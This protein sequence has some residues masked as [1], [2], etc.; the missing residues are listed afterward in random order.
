VVNC[1]SGDDTVR[2]DRLDHLK[3]CEHIERVK[4]KRARRR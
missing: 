3:G 1:G 4:A 2:A